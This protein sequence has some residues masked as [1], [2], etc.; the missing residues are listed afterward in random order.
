MSLVTELT[1]GLQQ[2]INEQ[3]G[4]I[5]YRRRTTI[6]GANPA[7]SPPTYVAPV[8]NGA[9][10]A[11]A[12]SINFGVDLT[13]GGVFTGRL[14]AGDTF[15]VAGDATT[16]TVTG[17]VVSPSNS[18][19]LTGVP[20]TPN[21]ARNAANGAA[22]TFAFVADTPNVSALI[23]DYPARLID[24]QT[25]TEK[26]HRVRMLAS[27]LAFDPQIGDI[28]ILTSGEVAAVMNVSHLEI[29]GQHY[30]WALRVRA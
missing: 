18:D 16:Y 22:V 4:L 26:D 12:S 29:Q 20:F 11:G 3:G 15:Q 21:L 17:Q 25:I 7:P 8:V 9:T 30:G 13:Q 10:L 23:T 27:A 6:S 2:L 5:T 28:V 1:Y 24:G 14:I 19:T